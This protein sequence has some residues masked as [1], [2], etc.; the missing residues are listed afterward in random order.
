MQVK[1][2][3][4]VQQ[5]NQMINHTNGNIV[6]ELL[7]GAEQVNNR[8]S[9]KIKRRILGIFKNNKYKFDIIKINGLNPNDIAELFVQS[10]YCQF[11]KKEIGNNNELNELFDR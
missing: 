3:K 10:C 2:V 9:I 4:L 6:D 1:I 5:L 8:K 7:N 11:D